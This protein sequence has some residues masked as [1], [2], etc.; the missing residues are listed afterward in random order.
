MH[1]LMQQWDVR[2]MDGPILR[3]RAGAV[4]NCRRASLAKLLPILAVVAS[5][6]T[7]TP[8]AGPS[9]TPTVMGRP[10]EAP[11]TSHGPS[12]SANPTVQH[13]VFMLTGSTHES[14]AQGAATLLK[15]G[16]VLLVG[17]SPGAAEIYDPTSGELTTT[18][19]L[20]RETLEPKAVTLADGKVL[21][22][23]ASSLYDPADTGAALYDPA[24]GKFR[25]LR[26][27]VDRADAAVAVLSDGRVLIAGG[28]DV[29]KSD[30]SAASAEIYDPATGKFTATGSMRLARVFATATTLSDGRVLIAGGGRHDPKA[31]TFTDSASAEVYDPVSGK[32]GRVGDMTTPREVH[33]ATLL[34]DGRVLVAGGFRQAQDDLEGGYLASAEVFDPATG[35]FS[36]TQPMLIDRGEHVA[37]LLP[38]GKVLLAG[39]ASEEN[40]DFGL[41]TAE[42]FDP[43]TSR[44]TVTGSMHFPRA[45]FTATLLASGDVLIAG[46]TEERQCELYRP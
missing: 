26:P 19:S 18:G 9:S 31:D 29:R 41:E 42:L 46:G 40:G 27:Q 1:Y 13:G 15:D 2:A 5:C 30:E 21:V 12:L 36:A 4:E 43:A 17:G 33:T 45:Y 44:F 20:P 6:Q 14:E 28:A 25:A 10:S 38:N 35:S 22:V 8:T 7:S 39:G 3:S 23:G 32:F 34:P 24:S 11:Q 16:R 37:V